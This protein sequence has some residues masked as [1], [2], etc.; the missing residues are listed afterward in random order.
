[1]YFTLLRSSAR[2]LSLFLFF[3][4]QIYFTF[5]ELISLNVQYLVVFASFPCPSWNFFLQSFL[6]FFK[7]VEHVSYHFFS[8]NISVT[9]SFFLSLSL[10]FLSRSPSIHSFPTFFLGLLLLPL[11]HSLFFSL[12]NLYLL[13]LSFSFILIFLIFISFFPG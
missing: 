13:F 6:Y 5:S 10:D 3:F 4:I 12:C 11:S 8:L 9:V 7:L 1:M 2:T